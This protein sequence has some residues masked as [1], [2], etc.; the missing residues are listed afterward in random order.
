[1]AGTAPRLWDHIRV[2]ALGIDVSSSRGLDLVLL[3]AGGAIL[4]TQRRIRPKEL[5]AVL[6]NLTPDVIAIDS[7]PGWGVSGG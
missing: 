4:E 1:M 3:D 6:A 2:R 5:P 7:P